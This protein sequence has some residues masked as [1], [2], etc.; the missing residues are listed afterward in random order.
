MGKNLNIGSNM[1]AMAYQSLQLNRL[2]GFS[3]RIPNMFILRWHFLFFFGGGFINQATAQIGEPIFTRNTSKETVWAK[4]VP[5]RAKPPF[6][7]IS[8][9]NKNAD[10]FWT[11]GPI[12]TKFGMKALGPQKS[13]IQKTRCPPTPSWIFMQSWITRELCIRLSPNVS[14]SFVSVVHSI[15]TKFARMI[16]GAQRN[17]IR[18]S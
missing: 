8:I 4:D 15:S 10:K 1:A 14:P 5:F 18:K 9:G 7:C 16:G 17:K 3:R 13:E 11:C 2:M 12:L 6:P